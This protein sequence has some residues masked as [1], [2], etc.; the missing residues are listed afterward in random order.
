MVK[1][2]LSG[3]KISLTVCSNPFLH[4]TAIEYTVPRTGG[5]VITIVS[6]SGKTVVLPLKGN[7]SAGRHRIT[8]NETDQ[9]GNSVPAGIYYVNIRSLH[10]MK[11]QR[12]CIVQ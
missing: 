12:F 10:G 6:G 11:A 7:S 5:I 1:N 2:Q 8:W 4:E 3:F 9:A